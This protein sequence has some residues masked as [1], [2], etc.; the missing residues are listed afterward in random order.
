MFLEAPVGIPNVFWEATDVIC[1]AQMADQRLTLVLCTE[2]VKESM[3]SSTVYMG[4]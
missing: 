1:T 2:T 4:S 3:P